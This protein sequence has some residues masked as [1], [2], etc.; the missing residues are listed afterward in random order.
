MARRRPRCRLT[1]T[2]AT[3]DRGNSRPRRITTGANHDN[4]GF[5]T[6]RKRPGAGPSSPAPGRVERDCLTNLMLLVNEGC[7]D[8]H[9]E[10]LSAMTD[11]A[12]KAG[13]PAPRVIATLPVCNIA[14]KCP[15]GVVASVQNAVVWDDVPASADPSVWCNGVLG[16][17]VHFSCT[18]GE[19]SLARSPR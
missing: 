5:D 6:P 1:D 17:P 14:R 7:V 8:V 3:H 13:R 19:L 10:T 9:G 11:A 18:T 12:D 4:G 15:C 2:T 16:S